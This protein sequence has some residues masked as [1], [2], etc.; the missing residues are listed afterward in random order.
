MRELTVTTQD[1][2]VLEV[3]DAA[4]SRG[5]VLL[6]HHG[7]PSSRALF[8][9]WVTEAESRGAR[10]ITYNRPGY[11]GS[12]PHPGRTVADVASDV[13]AIADQLGIERFATFGLSGGGPHTLACAALL[14]D[15]VTA[16]ASM[17]GVG[18][19][20]ADDLDF[21]AGMGED[22]VEEFEAAIAGR[23]VLAP[24]LEGLRAEMLEA[25]AAA[26]TEVLRTVLS[27][28][29]VAAM[30]GEIGEIFVAW[31]REAL[32][33]G[34]E[35]WVEDDLAFAAPWGFDLADI[36]VPI[37]L[38]QG[39]QDRMVPEAHGRWLAAHI[40]AVDARLRPDEGHL[41]LVT[42]RV[43]ETFDWLL[44]HN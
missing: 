26:V 33:K 17:A 41:T 21:T 6:F 5:P 40:P 1:G 13:R 12:D 27:D 37:L 8:S 32:E 7:T 31:T 16:A 44:S 3:T 35:G 22:N 34:V 25:D 23:D 18:P 19:N 30:S 10:L 29:D 24:M 4:E 2:R 42:T 38:W 15:R 28:V 11:G 20:D 14:P 43:G 9:P 36:Q 39:S